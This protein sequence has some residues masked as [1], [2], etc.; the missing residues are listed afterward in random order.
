MSGTVETPEEQEPE[1]ETPAEPETTENSVG[2]QEENETEEQSDE[3]EENEAEGKEELPVS[4][5]LESVLPQKFCLVLSEAGINTL[6]D[7]QQYVTDNELTAL[8]GIGPAKAKDIHGLV[9]SFL[10]DLTS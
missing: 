3:Q 1:T 2:E 8:E 10:A 9:E 5:P 7:Y 6:A 4:V